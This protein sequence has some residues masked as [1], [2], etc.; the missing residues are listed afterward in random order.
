MTVPNDG[1]ITV[2]AIN[3]ELGAVPK[4]KMDVDEILPRLLA[5][6]IDGKSIIKWSD[7]RGKSLIKNFGLTK[8]FNS[9]Q[10][11]QGNSFMITSYY[12]PIAAGWKFKVTLGMS[13]SWANDHP[14]WDYYF[15]YGTAGKF[16]GR[17]T[18]GRK[19]IIQYGEYDGKDL[20]T[21][22]GYYSGDSTN[23]PCSTQY[24]LTI[25]LLG[26]AS[27]EAPRGVEH[28]GTLAAYV[29]ANPANV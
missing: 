21:Q 18:F 20:F 1:P 16:Y 28:G 8:S 25:K 22:G 2:D 23:F 26:P 9:C 5:G 24:L 29:A 3:K 13:G 17:G 4:T 15:T 6:K 14:V 10:T 12:P 7:F 19:D 27:T 11:G